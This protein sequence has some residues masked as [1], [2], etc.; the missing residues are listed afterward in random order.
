MGTLLLTGFVACLGVQA[1]AEGSKD[2]GAVVDK[3]IK[4]MGGADKLGALKAATWKSKGVISLGGDD[5][6]FSSE[7]TVKGH[8][9]FRNDFTGDFGGMEIKGSVIVAGD[10]G[11]RKFNDMVTEMDKDALTNEKHNIYL[12]LI[13]VHVTALKSDHFKLGAVTAE[14]IDGKAASTVKIT[15]PDGK[16]FTMSFD[17][18]S[19]LPVRLVGNVWGF[20]GDEAPQEFTIGG[21]KDFDGLKKATKVSI[22]RSGEK[23]MTMEIVDF[24]TLSDVDAKTFAEPK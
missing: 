19:G 24:K 12:Q 10:K 23:F 9:H 3:A 6:K 16:D 14:K 18:E 11:W 22:K 21:Y 15:G 2:A 1:R 20:Q 8:D 17:N 13:P 7:T 4:A 5:N